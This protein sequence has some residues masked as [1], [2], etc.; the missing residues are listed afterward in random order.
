MSVETGSTEKNLRI[1]IALIK[2]AAPLLRSADV[3]M[4]GTDLKTLFDAVTNHAAPWDVLAV[5]EPARDILSLVSL[6]RQ[7]PDRPRVLLTDDQLLADFVVWA[8]GDNP[9]K[10]S[11]STVEQDRERERSYT[12]LLSAN[13]PDVPWDRVADTLL[14]S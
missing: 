6:E 8:W 7:L 3:A 2:L 12:R 4:R 11:P 1:M 13:D 10:W 14:N 9:F 5:T